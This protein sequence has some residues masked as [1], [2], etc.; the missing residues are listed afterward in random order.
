MV[1]YLVLENENGV[2][3]DLKFPANRGAWNRL[4]K[5]VG[6]NQKMR[7]LRPD[8]SEII[9]IPETME[10]LPNDVTRWRNCHKV[11]VVHCVRAGRAPT[12]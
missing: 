7:V 5:I 3:V 1:S 2:D 9:V 8:R 6:K 4:L 11:I 12:V 10:T